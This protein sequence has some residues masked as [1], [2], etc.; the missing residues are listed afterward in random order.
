MG[1][2]F[3]K[4][5]IFNLLAYTYSILNDYNSKAKNPYTL[6]NKQ[7]I[8]PHNN[9]IKIKRDVKLSSNSYLFSPTTYFPSPQSN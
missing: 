1:Y 7:R 2:F 6:L 4:M 5:A 3:K 8:F 9:Q